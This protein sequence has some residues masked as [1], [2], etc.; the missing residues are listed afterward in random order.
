M[1][2][3]KVAAKPCC[4]CI[5]L[6]F[7]CL[8]PLLI[9]AA[10]ATPGPCSEEDKAN[11]DEGWC[12]H[13]EHLDFD[14]HFQSMFYVFMGTSSYADLAELAHESTTAKICC[15]LAA[16]LGKA[17]LAVWVIGTLIFLMKRG[18]GATTALNPGPGQVFGQAA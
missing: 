5:G 13:R 12:E 17:W 4:L 18:G 15:M 3:A 2:D 7:C 10:I 1:E 9:L 16:I 11:N 8:I 6:W 14:M